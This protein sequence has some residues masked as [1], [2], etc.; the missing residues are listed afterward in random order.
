MMDVKKTILAAF[1]AVIACMFLIVILPTMAQYTCGLQGGKYAKYNWSIT[2]SAAGQSYTESATVD[3]NIQSVSGTS[4]SG[5][6]SF[7]VTGGGLP[8]G[9][10]SIPQNTQTFS[11]DVASGSGSMALISLLAIPANMTIDSN[12]PGVGD[13]KQIGSWSGRDTVVVNASGL[14]L[15]QG[16]AYYDQT[17]GI[18]LYSKTTW[19][20]GGYSID[21]K[22]EMV[23]TDLWSG[24]FGGGPLGLD[25]WMWAAII[26]I[27]VAAAVVVTAMMRRK[28]LLATAR[29]APPQPT[30]PQPPPPPPT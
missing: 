17:T 18:F 16:D 14:S 28:R 15:G 5:T 1:T 30:P 11:G 22:L 24:G 23:G 12:I 8:S 9:L 27:I 6:T 10:L 3:V 26:V 4:Y 25:L 21:Y 2:V 7:T 13:V 19:N 20:L 29:P